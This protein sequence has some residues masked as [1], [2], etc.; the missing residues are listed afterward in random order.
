MAEQVPARLRQTVSW[1]LAAAR[2]RSRGLT[3]EQLRDAG[4]R[5]AHYSVLATIVEVGPAS[6]AALGRLIG[7]DRSDMVAVLNDLAADGYVERNPDPD[8]RRRNVVRITS[9]GRG[10]LRRFDKMVAAADAE[11]L[12]PL[13]AAE[14]EQLRAL[15]ER[16]ATGPGHSHP[17]AHRTPRA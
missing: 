16:V 8:D 15:L 3:A 7:L 13:S 11:L 9:A 10:A 17:A 4:V 1:W 12:S 5:H 2:V 14:R 6:Q